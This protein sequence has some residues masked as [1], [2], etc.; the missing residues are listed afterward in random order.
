MLKCSLFLLLI[1]FKWTKLGEERPESISLCEAG[2]KRL[3]PIAMNYSTF[4]IF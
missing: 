1:I 4:V 2:C 3:N